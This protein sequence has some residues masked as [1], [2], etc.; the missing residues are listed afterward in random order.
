[1]RPF[2]RGDRVSGLIQKALSDLLQK[3][4]KDPRLHM[5]TITRVKMSPDLK[6]AKIYFCTGSGENG[7]EAA[8][9]GLQTAMGFI[10]RSLAPE[11][12]L[13]YMP[14]LKFFYD[15]SFDYAL[16]IYRILDSIKQKDETNHSKFEGK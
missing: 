11:L 2:S 14:E 4:I 5:I 12:G 13:R 16:H 8:A 6:F 15:E 9:Q 10:K 3:D 1:M 7:R